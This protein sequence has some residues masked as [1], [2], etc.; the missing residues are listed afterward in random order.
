MQKLKKWGIPLLVLTAALLAVRAM[1]APEPRGPRRRAGAAQTRIVHALQVTADTL[2]AE[3]ELSGRII[4]PRRI[5]LV[6][7][8][9]GRILEK[10][11]RCREGQTFQKG[12]ILFR[13]DRRETAL[14]IRTG[15]QKLKTSLSSLLP[16][17]RS[18][19]LTEADKWAR[20]YDS[21]RGMSLP[22]L[23]EVTSDRENTILGRYNVL[24][25]YFALQKQL[26][27]YGRHIYRA[28]FD[29]TIT[30]EI[31]SPGGYLSGGAAVAE[32]I[33]RDS[34]LISL[35]VSPAQAGFL[36]EGMSLQILRDGVF[37]DSARILRIS[38]VLSEDMQSIPLFAALDSAG[39]V[40]PG[41]YLQARLQTV[42]IPDAAALPRRAVQNNAVSVIADSTVTEHP[43]RVVFRTDDSLYIA[44]SQLN[45][46]TLAADF[47][48]NVPASVKIKARRTKEQ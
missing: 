7:Q 45:G 8:V 30:R 40:F 11:F 43:V 19:L 10:D 17:L 42:P 15:I 18:D 1:T 41:E 36:H 2:R 23:P 31:N 25:Q 32:A 16:E 27:L 14:D 28:P 38:D 37:L 21:L 13:L 22:P 3:I 24:Q 20:F 34:A 5:N 26:L 6:P 12:D 48:G 33:R 46:K 44:A 9:S 4:A 39:A 29:G 35:S 47:I